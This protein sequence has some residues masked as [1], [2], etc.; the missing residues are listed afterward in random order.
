[1]VD[2]GPP[3]WSSKAGMDCSGIPRES[4]MI[5]NAGIGGMVISVWVD[6]FEKMLEVKGLS[7]DGLSTVIRLM[8]VG[9]LR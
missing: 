1:M 2:R 4:R 9:A 7:V 8:A 6:A 3:V 5:S